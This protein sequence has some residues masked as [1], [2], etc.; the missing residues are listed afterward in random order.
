MKNK[1][2]IYKVTH[3]E[4][5]ESYIGATTKTMGQRKEDHLQKAYKSS[6]G[7]FQEAIATQGPEAFV[8][9]QIDTA[10]SLDEMAQKEKEYVVKYNSKENGYN[11]DCGGG[12]QKTV[13]QYNMEDRKLVNAFGSLKKAADAVGANKRSISS[14]CLGV[15]KTCKGYY[16]SYVHPMPLVMK[17]Q[18]KKTVI[19]MDLNG[20]PIA[21]Y[22][23]LTMASRITG[24]SKTCISRCCRGE[25]D[26]SGGYRW[27]YI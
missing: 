7:R 3:K 10:N 4:S 26:T 27:K 6:G 21:D 1:G 19:Q 18:R 12:I 15:N 9:T 23:S 8:W 13:F 5:G 24:I 2:I 25:R 16:W 14:A 17:D 22:D 11:A 20:Y